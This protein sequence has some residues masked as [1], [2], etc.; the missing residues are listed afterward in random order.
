MVW[1]ARETEYD[2]MAAQTLKGKW[3]NLKMINTHET[4][5]L[6]AEKTNSF[7]VSR[8]KKTIS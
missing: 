4:I 2:Y 7:R 3:N 6:G 1:T 8:Q 5:T